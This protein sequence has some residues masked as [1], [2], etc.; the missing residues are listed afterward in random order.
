MAYPSAAIVFEK[1]GFPG[2]NAMKMISREVK[3]QVGR[4]GKKTFRKG[5]GLQSE[6]RTFL[7]FLEAYKPVE[8]SYPEVS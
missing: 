3:S 7:K 2:S 6:L 4:N 8:H 1:Y 5:Y